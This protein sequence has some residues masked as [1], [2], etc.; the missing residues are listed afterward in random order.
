[1][2]FNPKKL[3]RKLDYLPR[4]AWYMCSLFIAGPIGIL[5]VYLV[6]YVLDRMIRDY[7][8]DGREREASSRWTHA[9]SFY[10]DE[11]CTVTDEEDIERRW[12]RT[13]SSAR[14]VHDAAEKTEPQ[15][16]QT[17]VSAV[18]REGQEAL[19]RIRRANDLIADPEL[20]AR[21]D[22][23]EMSCGQILSILEQRPQLLPQ[24]RTFLRY[25][26]PATLR[27]LDARAKLE[28]TASTPKALEVRQRI[29]D[30]LG[31]ID[32][33]FRKQVESLDEYRFIDLESE[34][35]VLR[36]MLRADGLISEEQE[37]SDP[38]AEVLSEKYGKPM[39]GC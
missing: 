38:F 39:G 18:I 4:W 20:S 34:I 33:A 5:G 6:F 12:Q 37:E 2:K 23:I 8:Q 28:N 36:D 25:Y 19:R 24:L 22:A 35:D 21:I 1:M 17:D 31:V 9:D 29:S 13:E 3:K 32:G 27:L 11:D 16:E 7:E 30:A 10:E 15:G 14:N 26:L